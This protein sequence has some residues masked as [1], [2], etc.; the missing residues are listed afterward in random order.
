MRVTTLRIENFCSIKRFDLDLGE[1]TVLI[2]E[3]N[4]G[5]TAVLDDAWALSPGRRPTPG[6]FRRTM[7]S[8][9]GS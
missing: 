9:E 7:V 5:K 3:N 8:W 2:G 4:T 1:I 6:R